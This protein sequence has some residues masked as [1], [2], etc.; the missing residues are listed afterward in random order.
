LW[1][2]LPGGFDEPRQLLGEEEV[3]IAVYEQPE[4]I[5]DILATIRECGLQLIDT[6]AERG[7]TADVM[8][9]HE[10]MAGKSGS[11]WGPHTINEFIQPYTLPLW[12]HAKER[13]GCR[14]FMQ[15]SDGNMNAVVAATVDSGV[16]VMSPMEPGSGMD[17]VATRA[18]HDTG[19]AFIGG[20]DKYMITTE[21]KEIDRELEYKVPAMLKTGGVVFSLDH[22]IPKG[23]PVENY[24]YYIKRFWEIAD[25]CM[26]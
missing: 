1:F 12:E 25:D 3:C 2:C 4:M 23:S 6:L 26:K 21:K 22:R 16:N 18:A 5:H 24:R 17:I 14:L 19:L 10:D 7:I 15:D 20:L 13:L 9:T 11:L 8:F